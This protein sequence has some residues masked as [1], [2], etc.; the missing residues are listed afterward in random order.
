MVLILDGN[1]ENFAHAQKK[2]GLFR[3]KKSI[4]DYS[5]SNQMPKTDQLTEIAPYVP[6]YFHVI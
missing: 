2:L 1:T 4:C 3:E 6:I 5:R